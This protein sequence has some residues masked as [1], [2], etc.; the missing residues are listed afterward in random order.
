MF[1]SIY[2]NISMAR[3]QPVHPA[4]LTENSVFLVLFKINKNLHYVGSFESIKLIFCSIYGV[5]ETDMLLC[6]NFM[7][8]MIV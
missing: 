3:V 8:K 1:F 6:S 4:F 7:V 2:I 5:R